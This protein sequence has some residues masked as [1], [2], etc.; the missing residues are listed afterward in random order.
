MATAPART[1]LE[2]L[3]IPWAAASQTCLRGNLCG[4]ATALGSQT[5]ESSHRNLPPHG[6]GAPSLAIRLSED[7]GGS[8]EDLRLLLAPG[9]SLGGARR[10]LWKGSGS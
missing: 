7:D 1:R 10:R 4:V 5:H 3:A 6:P 8:D 9:S 2:D